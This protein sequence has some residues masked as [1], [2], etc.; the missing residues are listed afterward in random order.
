VSGLLLLP[1][2]LA[3][4]ASVA[5]AVP[6]A[7]SV[8]R[9]LALGAALAAAALAAVAP[10]VAWDGRWLLLGA[11]TGLDAAGRGAL[12]A[13]AGLLL[14]ARQGDRARRPGATPAWRALLAGGL[15]ASAVAFDA[16]LLAAGHVAALL[17]AY[18][19]AL[20]RPEG[21]RAAARYMAAAMAGEALLVDAL[22]EFGHAA[23]SAHLDAMRAAAVGEVGLAAPLLLVGAF[24]LPI[25]VAGLERLAAPA[26]ALAAVG[27][28]ATSRLAS[29][30][31][32][33]RALVA[34]LV[35]LGFAGLA[36]LGASLGGVVPPRWPRWSA[37]AVPGRAGDAAP[38]AAAGH[39][40]AHPAPPAVAPWAAAAAWLDVLEAR[41]GRAAGSGLL[42]L[43]S[44]A[45]L[46]LGV[47][48][49]G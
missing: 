27:A 22:A 30:P 24:G 28:L 43:A 3:G 44:M 9:G 36:A 6:S 49:R 20:G 8:G 39:P 47:A 5:W 31:A 34:A 46:A 13:A 17:A 11:R 23:E 7:R 1:A 29:G 18:G 2:L 26:A 10:S 15:C 14:L 35:L 33:P 32:T 48:L 45:A 38:T 16:G 41:L 4:A 40:G 37:P 12:A 25:L 42:V 21:R 19:L